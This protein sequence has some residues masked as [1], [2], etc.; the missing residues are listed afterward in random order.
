MTKKLPSD[1]LRAMIEVKGWGELGEPR[2]PE[3]YSPDPIEIDP[4]TNGEGE[5]YNLDPNTMSEDQQALIADCFRV[6]AACLTSADA[7]D[8]AAMLETLMEGDAS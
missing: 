5:S 8:Y 1:Y 7:A 2:A 6:V 4:D 3:T